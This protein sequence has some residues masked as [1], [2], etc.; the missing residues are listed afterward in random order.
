[1]DKIDYIFYD[2]FELFGHI[3]TIQIHAI[4]MYL[5]ARITESI[6]RLI[7]ER[8]QYLSLGSQQEMGGIHG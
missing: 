1:M 7:S 8:L 3:V 2:T 5:L 4:F 6:L